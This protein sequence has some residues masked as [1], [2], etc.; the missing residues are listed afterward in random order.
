MRTSLLC[1]FRLSCDAFLMDLPRAKQR[2]KK[3]RERERERER[4]KEREGR[5]ERE[6][7]REKILDIHI[8]RGNCSSNEGE[9][10][11]SLQ[12]NDPTVV[13]LAITYLT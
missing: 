7:E 9:S 3:R 12:S 6:R 13:L 8:L 11:V 1:P 4:E 5:R 10:K 2:E